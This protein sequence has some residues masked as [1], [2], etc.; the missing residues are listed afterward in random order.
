MKKTGK[1]ERFIGLKNITPFM[2]K[3][4]MLRQVETPMRIFKDL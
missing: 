3:V 1:T 4:I 2:E